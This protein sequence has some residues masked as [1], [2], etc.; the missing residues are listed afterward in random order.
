MRASLLAP[1]LILA[2]GL[3]VPF[4]PSGS[5]RAEAQ[6]H[7]AAPAS[8]PNDLDRLLGRLDSEE[9]AL[10]TEQA[11]LG[12]KLDLTRRRMVARGRAYYRLMHAGLLP[13]GAGFDAL[14]D[15]AVQVERTRM[16]LE[17]DLVSESS[18]LKRGGEIEARLARIRAERA[19]LDVQRE[20]MARARMALQ[21]SDERRAAFARAFETSTRPDAMAIYG[22]DTGP[23]EADAKAGFRALKGRLPFPI[24]GRAEVKKI[25]RNGGAP[26]VELLAA[27]GSPV[28]AVAAGRV[29]FADRYDEYGLTVIVDHGDRY[30]S[31]YANPRSTEVHAGDSVPSGGRIG[32]VG[33]DGSHGT[34]LY[35]ELRH[36]A[37]I[38]DPSPWLG[39]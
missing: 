15:H 24:A 18:L 27:A 17:R 19:P 37:S 34:A 33:G 4:A 2:A 38:V 1:A 36:N 29:A 7:A 32:L 21:E 8:A 6:G 31:L 22:A 26:G 25:S 12:P 13:A 39:I 20:A 5:A 23:V 30:Y 28:R 35:F 3:C 11:E 10:R 16:A 9:R 14:V